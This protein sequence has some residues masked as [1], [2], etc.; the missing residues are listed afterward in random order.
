MEDENTEY[1]TLGPVSKAINMVARYHMEGRESE[2]YKQHLIKQKDFMWVCPQGLM[3]SGTNGSQLWDLAF[4]TQAIVEGGMAYD[5]NNKECFVKVLEWLDE[6][7]IK[8]NPKHYERAY[9]HG[10]KG[11]WPFSTREQSYVV[12]DCTGEG[13]KAVLYLQDLR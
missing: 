11:A 12:S 4:I 8:D 5:E 9:R 2:A 3:M 7:Q 6:C 1:Q 13:L 10:T